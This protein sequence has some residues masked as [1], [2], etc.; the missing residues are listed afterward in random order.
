MLHKSLFA[1]TTALRLSTALLLTSLAFVVGCGDKS[2]DTG[3][4]T[5]APE[6]EEVDSGDDSGDSGEDTGEDTGE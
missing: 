3:S 6:E 5:S 4:D 2:E 1:V